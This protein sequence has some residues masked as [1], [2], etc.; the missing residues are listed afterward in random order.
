M[1]T[2][3]GHLSPWPPVQR[4]A[5]TRLQLHYCY[6][7]ILYIKESLKC[8]EELALYSS[9]HSDRNCI[10]LGRRSVTKGVLYSTIHERLVSVIY[11]QQSTLQIAL[12]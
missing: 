8:V 10:H 12:A 7:L 11:V 2:A 5:Q 4:Q 3:P 1:A 6:V 9:D